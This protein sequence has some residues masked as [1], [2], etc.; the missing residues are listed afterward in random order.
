MSAFLIYCGHIDYDGDEV[1]V[2]TIRSCLRWFDNGP[3][4]GFGACECTEP[5]PMDAS[6]PLARYFKSEC[7]LS[8]A[9]RS[10]AD[11]RDLKDWETLTAEY[12]R[13]LQEMLGLWPMPERTD[14]RP[15]I[16]GKI[17]HPEFTVEKLHSRRRPAFT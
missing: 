15:V 1:R 2:R 12:R 13:Q 5:I 7:E 11:I 4:V 17:E 14:L 3:R 10:L 6:R 9:S 16:T 8:L